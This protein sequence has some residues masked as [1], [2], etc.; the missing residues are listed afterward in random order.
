MVTVN[1]EE[2]IK[3]Q[4]RRQLEKVDHELSGYKVILF[5]SRAAGCARARSDFDVG[6]IGEQPIPLTTF[7]RIEDLFDEINTLYT[8]DWVDLNRAGPKLRQEAMKTM[9]LL[10]EG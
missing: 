3:Q 10:Y 8:I 4:I 1:Q 2:Y 6:I 9:E 5:G 7:Y